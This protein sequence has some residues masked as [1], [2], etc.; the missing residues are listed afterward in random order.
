MVVRC[1]FERLERHE[2]GAQA[3]AQMLQCL[4]AHT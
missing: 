3:D 4:A 1:A 2:I